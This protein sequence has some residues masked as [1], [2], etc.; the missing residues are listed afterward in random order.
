[1]G[2]A[3]N[4]T[5]RICSC[6]A[7]WRWCSSPAAEP[8]RNALTALRFGWLP[9]Q[10]SGEVVVVA[11]DSPSLKQ[12][13]VWPWPRGMHASLLDVL[14][15]AKAS[16]IVFD[17][18]FSA[19]STPDADRAFAEAL[20]RAGGSVVLPAF[21][22]VARERG[23]ATI[24]V[25][26]PMPLFAPHAWSATINIVPDADGVVRQYAFGEMLDGKFVPSVGA[27][28]AGRWQT[29]R[30]MLVDFGI[31]AAS[32]PTVSYIDVLRRDPAA[33]QTVQGRKIIVGATAIELGDRVNVPNGQ[34]IPG[35]LLPAPAADRCCRAGR[36]SRRRRRVARRRRRD[37][38]RDAPPVAPRL[39]PA[40]VAIL[41]GRGRVEGG[42][43][44]LGVQP[45]VLDTSF[46]TPSSSLIWSRS[47]S[48]RSTCAACSG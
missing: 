33:M 31:R 42:A 44:L 19:V 1:M 27:M 48:M 45:I 40:R 39:A 3:R 9:R 17:V 18:D 7:Y 32:V 36:C 20:R 2:D 26:R 24:Q 10:A 29:G 25:D 13:G 34:V 47:R 15:G 38:A 22:Q 14:D 12:T 43:T 46:L 6:S 16:D 30:S 21:K 28:L 8:L 23:A 37:H 5:D 11:I 41:L 4:H 35:P